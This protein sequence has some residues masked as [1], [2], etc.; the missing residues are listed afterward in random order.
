MGFKGMK[1]YTYILQS[2]KDGKYYVGHTSKTPEIRL[3]Q[4]N[5]KCVFS[6]KH[7]T[8]FKLVAIE[9]FEDRHDAIAKERK[10]K[11]MHREK[12]SGVVSSPARQVTG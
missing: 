12:W 7:R 9:K 3:E 6:T 11:S 1:F 8:P 10:L 5:R 4:H 2:L